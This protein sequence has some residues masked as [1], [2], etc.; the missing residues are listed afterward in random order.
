[1]INKR[2]LDVQAQCSNKLGFDHLNIDQGT[3]DWL[4]LRMG[5]VSASKAYIL[6]MDDALAPFPKGLDIIAIKRGVN[7]VTLN[8]ETYQGTKADCTAWVRNKHT[9]I[10]SDTKPTYM[11]E[12]I[13]QNS[14]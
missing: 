13:A 6:L 14:T 7:E 4:K 12:L 5:V 10:P 1:M 3:H 8:G 9:G 2:I 11:N